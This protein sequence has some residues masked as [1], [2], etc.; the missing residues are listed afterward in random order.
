[1][2]GSGAES[3]EVLEFGNYLPSKWLLNDSEVDEE[4]LVEDSYTVRER[5]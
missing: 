4:L 5:V 1:M 2:Y 3:G